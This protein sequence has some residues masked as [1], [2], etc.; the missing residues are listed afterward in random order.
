MSLVYRDFMEFT[1][2]IFIVLRPACVV[3]LLFWYMYVFILVQIPFKYKR[4]DIVFKR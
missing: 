1:T 2:E 4:L 3:I